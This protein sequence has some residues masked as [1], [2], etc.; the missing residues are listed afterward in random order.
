MSDTL[1]AVKV[2]AKLGMDHLVSTVDIGVQCSE[3]YVVLTGNVDNYAQKTHADTLVQS[4]DGVT[5]VDNQLTVGR[6][7]PVPKQPFGGPQPLNEDEQAELLQVIH[8]EVHKAM[9]LPLD[10]VEVRVEPTGVVVLDGEVQSALFKKALEDTIWPVPGV[11]WIVNRLQVEG[12]EEQN[13]ADDDGNVKERLSSAAAGARLNAKL[14]ANGLVREA[15]AVKTEVDGDDIVVFGDIDNW[16]LKKRI[17]EMAQDVFSETVV[18]EITVAANRDMDRELQVAEA[19]KMPAGTIFHQ[20]L[21][22]H[23]QVWHLTAKALQE[24]NEELE[25]RISD[26]FGA[27]GDS[28]KAK[29]DTMGTAYLAGTVSTEEDIVEAEKLVWETRGVRHVV[30]GLRVQ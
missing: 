13:A 8:D 1:L 6:E 29:V 10:N 21:P 30:N 22:P 28:V 26:R 27:R 11:A 25:H 3:G 12:D 17:V 15:L 20:T 18:D 7:A 24:T 16:S 14:V 9:R 4:V 19:P 2:N 5:G 23:H